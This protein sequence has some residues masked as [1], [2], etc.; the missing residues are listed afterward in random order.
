MAI[1]E[2][3]QSEVSSYF[4][5]MA[6]GKIQVDNE[7]SIGKP[8]GGRSNRVIHYRMTYPDGPVNLPVQ[9][10][11]SETEQVVRQAKE[12]AKA[13]LGIKD[14]SRKRR[15]HSHKRK[16]KGNTKYLQHRRHKRSKK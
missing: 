15:H 11:T 4:K 6:E 7:G 5:A 2:P 10:V 9:K 1:R 3:S 8:V 14:H 12:E 13:E 16:R